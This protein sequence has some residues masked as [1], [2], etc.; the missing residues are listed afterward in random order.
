VAS[1]VA[2]YR[3]ASVGWRTVTIVVL[4]MVIAVCVVVVVSELVRRR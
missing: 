4:V 3:N 1:R 2:G